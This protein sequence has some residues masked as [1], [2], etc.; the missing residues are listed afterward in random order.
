[1]TF[2]SLFSFSLYLIRFNTN[3]KRHFLNNGDWKELQIRKKANIYSILLIL[4]SSRKNQ[5]FKKLWLRHLRLEIFLTFS[6][7]F[8]FFEAHFLTTIFL[9]KKELFVYMTASASHVRSKDVENLI[10]RHNRTFRYTCMYK[11]TCWQSSGIIIILCK[12]YI[13]YTDR[14]LDMFFLVL[15]VILSELHENPRRKDWVTEKST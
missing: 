5:H 8:W 4:K 1:M 7:G 15:A 10:F 14:L 3:N 9:M 12:Y 13:R 2:I 6:W 11:Q